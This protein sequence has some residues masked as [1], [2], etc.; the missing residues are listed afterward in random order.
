MSEPDAIA[1]YYDDSKNPDTWYLPGVPLADIAHERWDA[2]PDW[3][4]ESA[5][6]IGWY[7]QTRPA[8]RKAAAVSKVT[9]DPK[10]R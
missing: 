1:R 5:D 3:L 4:K 9:D 2:L 7:S 6:A 8:V 10:E